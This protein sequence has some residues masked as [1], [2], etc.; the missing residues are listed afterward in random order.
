MLSRGG[1]GKPLDGT[2]NNPTLVYFRRPI[3]AARKYQA[4]SVASILVQIEIYQISTRGQKRN[5]FTDM[6][7][8]K[9][10]AYGA[11][12]RIFG[13]TDKL[14]GCF[15]MMFVLL[16]SLLDDIRLLTFCLSCGCQYAVF[17]IAKG[18]LLPCRLPSFVMRKAMN[19]IHE[20]RPNAS[21]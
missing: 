6:S 20:L 2:N 13:H 21:L 9:R 19:C 1:S 18:G 15:Y 5:T 17:R 10:R 14:R 16:H 11:N 3:R 7:C 4:V 12:I 8:P